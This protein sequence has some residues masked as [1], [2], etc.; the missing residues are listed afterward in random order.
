M[1]IACWIFTE[2]EAGS[3]HDTFV[4][5]YRNVIYQVSVDCKSNGKLLCLMHKALIIEKLHIISKCEIVNK[6]LFIYLSIHIFI[7]CLRM[8]SVAQIS[9][10]PMIE[11]FLS[12][13]LEELWIGSAVAK[14]GQISQHLSGVCLCVR[15]NICRFLYYIDY[16]FM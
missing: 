11:Q 16:N 14:F 12:N 6:H 4:T 1:G 9:L 15:L 5:I 3:T 13:Y 2:C 7:A 8:L 10:H